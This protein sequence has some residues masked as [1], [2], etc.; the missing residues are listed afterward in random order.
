MN[1]MQVIQDSVREQEKKLLLRLIQDRHG[2]DQ[3]I[4]EIAKRVF[5]DVEP[6]HNWKA[7]TYSLIDAL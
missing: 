1:P 5:P 6:N 3:R 2:I 4:E 7:E